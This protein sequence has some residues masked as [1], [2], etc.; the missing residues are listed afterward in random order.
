MS[1]SL[2]E[3]RPERPFPAWPDGIR[4]GAIAV[5]REREQGG[6]GKARGELWVLLHAALSLCVR[7]R[8]RRAGDVHPEDTHD[9]VAQKALELMTQ[10]DA[11][12][13]DP[14]TADVEQIRAFVFTVAGHGVLN[15]VRTRRSELDRRDVLQVPAVMAAQDAWMDGAVYAEAIRQ[16]LARLTPRARTVW[17]LRVLLEL[18]SQEVA[19]HPQVRMTRTSVDVTL[20]RA[21]AAVRRCLEERSLDWDRMP[22]GTFVQLWE[23]LE[24]GR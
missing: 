16:C 10:I 11:G 19:R 17:Y 18:P 5:G 9:L 13:W 2:A 1:R 15:L 23:L 22:E 14:A 7:V 12:T 8:A 3:S 20:F 24:V 4:R 6:T 21:R